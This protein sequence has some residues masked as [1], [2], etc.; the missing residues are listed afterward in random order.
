MPK[1]NFVCKDGSV[2]TVE[3]PAGT[4]IM[5]A[6]VENGIDGVVAECGGV[7]SC[8][9]CHCYVD[10]TWFDRLEPPSDIE[11]DMIDFTID[12]RPTSR[13]TC[14]IILTDELDGITVAVPERQY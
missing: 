11:R 6:A 4:S 2:Q 13:L 5:K 12:P 9:T 8:A 1:V 14:Q 10:E 7:C 3:V